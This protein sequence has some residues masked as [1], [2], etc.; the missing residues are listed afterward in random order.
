L[1]DT[2]LW[3]IASNDCGID[4]TYR[5]TG[6]PIGVDAGFVKCLINTRLIGTKRAAALQR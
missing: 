6:N 4:R 1:S 3:S 2:R 5:N